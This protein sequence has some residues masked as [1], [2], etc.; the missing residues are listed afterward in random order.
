VDEFQAEVK[1]L[2]ASFRSETANAETSDD[3]LRNERIAALAAAMEGV[4]NGVQSPLQRIE[5]GLIP[6]VTFAIIPIFALANAGIDLTGIR[7]GEALSHP[8]TQGVVLG[9]VVGKFA[10]IGLFSWVAVRLGWGRLPAGVQWKHLL[11]AA[12]LGGI[13]FT[14]SLF[15]AQLAFKDPAMVEEAKLGIL[16]ASAISAALGFAWLYASAPPSHPRG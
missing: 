15:I 16:L 12:W 6:W 13:G 8:V 7:W 11:G 9:L 4:A 1:K 3:P 2:Q 14:M 10:G 5:H